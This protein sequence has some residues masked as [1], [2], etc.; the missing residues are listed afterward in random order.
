MQSLA[1]FAS[2]LL[3]GTGSLQASQL[4]CIQ[5]QLRLTLCNSGAYSTAAGEA[6]PEVDG[7]E[8]IKLLDAKTPGLLLLDV[9]S[10]E[11]SITNGS[12][13]EQE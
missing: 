12:G 5:A 4:L 9:R 2:P 6:L 1:R 7:A 8:L 11:V 10:P 3:R 13:I